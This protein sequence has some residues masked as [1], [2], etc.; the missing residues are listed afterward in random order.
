[1]RAEC[2]LCAAQETLIFQ[3]K[4]VQIDGYGASWRLGVPDLRR[5]PSEPVGDR[6]RPPSDVN[7]WPAPLPS[8]EGLPYIKR[9]FEPTTVPA[10]RL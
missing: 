10:I 2:L 7:P 1:V 5:P 8:D 3:G 4:S 6:G 9:C